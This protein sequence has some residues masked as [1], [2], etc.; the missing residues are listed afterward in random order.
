[1]FE[2]W[3]KL[4]LGCVIAPIGFLLLASM[5]ALVVY[6]PAEV[7]AQ[8]KCLEAGYPEAKV[9]WNL[10]RYCTNLDGVVTVT[11]DQLED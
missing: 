5:L 10:K 6:V 7:L 9:T 8:E 3:E 1:M 2:W 11:V 4:L